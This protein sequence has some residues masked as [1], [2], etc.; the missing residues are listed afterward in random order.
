MLSEMTEN[1]KV[2]LTEQSIY[3]IFYS[4]LFHKQKSF[5]FLCFSHDTSI[6]FP[7][8]HNIECEKQECFLLPDR[9]MKVYFSSNHSK[10]IPCV[11]N[12]YAECT[13][14]GKKS[15]SSRKP[16]KSSIFH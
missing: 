16:L 15:D 4:W 11:H 13:E 3:Q 2:Y 14:M 10:T 9:K 5:F 1:L 12:R 6:D 7:F 8:L